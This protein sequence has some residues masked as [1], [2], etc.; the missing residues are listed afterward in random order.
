M[1]KRLPAITIIK[2]TREQKGWFFE[3]E[4]K[5]S[6][7]VQILGTIDQKLD[8]G[9]YSIVG[10]EHIVSI[11]RKNS[12]CELFLNHSP[13]SNKERFERE[14]E[15]FQEVKHKYLLIE[16][17]LSNDIMSMSIPQMIKGMPGST[18]IRWVM[19]LQIDYGI[20]PIFAGNAGQKMASVIFRN[21]ARRYL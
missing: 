2:D 11:E 14:M 19:N 3:E 15:R 9:D 13:V 17:S 7:K 16:S 1:A 18:I 12:F 6:G 4:P 21:I 10:L 8:A 20:I 5:K